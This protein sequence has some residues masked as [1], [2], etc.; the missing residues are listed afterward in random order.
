M[1]R[2]ILSKTPKTQSRKTAA[3]STFKID[4]KRARTGDATYSL[5]LFEVFM[6]APKD[7]SDV[8]RKMIDV[9]H[10]AYVK[11]GAR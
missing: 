4:T 3:A 11:G 5:K 1:A 6:H 9:F 10:G 8:I 2:K 7:T